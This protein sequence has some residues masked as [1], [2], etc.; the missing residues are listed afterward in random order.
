L[1]KQITHLNI[2]IKKTDVVCSKTIADIFAL[3]L[4]LCKKLIVCNFGDMSPTRRC[5]SPLFY[6]LSNN[7]IPSTLIKLKV[8]VTSLV[9]CLYLLDGPLV[10][11][12]TLIINVQQIFHTAQAID[13]TVSILFH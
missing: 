13:P 9:D 3:I 4:S 12:S 6:L 10:C 11:L 2:D 5:T 1:T 7:Y 8:N